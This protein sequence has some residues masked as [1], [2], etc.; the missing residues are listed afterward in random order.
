MCGQKGR[1]FFIVNSRSKFTS[2]IKK[3]IAWY[4]DSKRIYNLSNWHLYQLSYNHTV[5]LL[6]RLAERFGNVFTLSEQE[7]TEIESTHDRWV[8]ILLSLYL[9][10][11]ISLQPKSVSLITREHILIDPPVFSIEITRLK[12][13]KVGKSLLEEYCGIQ[14]ADNDDVSYKGY[15]VAMNKSS[16]Y[17]KLLKYLVRALGAE[18]KV[19]DLP[20][21]LLT[22]LFVKNKTKDKQ[23]TSDS[24]QRLQLTANYIKNDIFKPAAK[25]YKFTIDFDICCGKE[26]VSLQP[27]SKKSLRKNQ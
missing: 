20:Q 2:F 10:G 26:N 16:R 12:P 13:L 23:K 27:I 8:E 24:I 18:R 5:D 4:E 11:Y 7:I 22:A 19:K 15:P 6:N 9:K 17:F 21:S 1:R 25:Q 3:Y 14:I